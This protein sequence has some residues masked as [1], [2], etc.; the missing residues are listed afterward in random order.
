MIKLISFGLRDRQPPEAQVIIGCRSLPN[1]HHR[2]DLRTRTGLDPEVQAHVFSTAGAT[3]MLASLHSRVLDGSIPDGSGIAFGCHGGRHRS[4][5]MAERFR[6]LLVAAG[7]NVSVE[8][9]GL[10]PR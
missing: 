8:H 10:R 3:G 4:V 6:L 5:T 9:L 7:H 1:P 2:L